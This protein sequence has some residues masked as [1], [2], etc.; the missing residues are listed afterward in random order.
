MRNPRPILRPSSR[1]SLALNPGY[2][3]H[4][5]PATAYVQ[6]MLFD[7]P[8]IPSIHVNK[9]RPL[10]RS[11]IGSN[12]D[13]LQQAPPGWSAIHFTFSAATP[14][15]L[16]G[17]ECRQQ[18]RPMPPAQ[19]GPGR[20]KARRRRHTLVPPAAGSDMTQDL[21][22]EKEDVR[23]TRHVAYFGP[24]SYQIAAIGS[25]RIDRRTRANRL[26]IAAALIG[27][28]VLV[29]AFLEQRQ[30]VAIAGGVILLVAALLQVAWPRRHFILVLKT[31][32]G[33][34]AAYVSRKRDLVTRAKEAIESAFRARA[35]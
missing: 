8:R 1:I 33:E 27:V 12:R 3:L 20:W 18:R 13:A 35:G 23:I 6:R 26:A 22:F 9:R 28:A 14:A 10:L 24:T 34:V 21:L 2:E 31:P 4:V 16:A 11:P 25:V 7:A 5:V 29:I 32:G 30:D 17:A 15:W 19:D